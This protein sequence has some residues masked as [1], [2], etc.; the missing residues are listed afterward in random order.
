VFL[1]RGG[2]EPQAV[3]FPPANQYT[4]QAEL[5]A[6]AV[7]DDTPVPT[8]PQDGVA[9]MRVIERVLKAAQM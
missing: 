4:I 6:Q 5:F 3:T 9:N 2:T 8:P 7:L 1:T